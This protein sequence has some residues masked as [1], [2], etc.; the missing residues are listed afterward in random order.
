MPAARLEMAFGEKAGLISPSDQNVDPAAPRSWLRPG[1][2]LQ[3]AKQVLMFEV[4][5]VA[6]VSIMDVAFFDPLCLRQQVENRSKAT[7]L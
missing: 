7:A 2:N 1:S 3:S 6:F 5:R 4:E